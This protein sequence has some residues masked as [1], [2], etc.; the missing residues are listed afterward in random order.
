[1]PRVGQF[2]DQVQLDFFFPTDL[3]G[4]THL[5]LAMIDCATLLHQVRRCDSRQAEYVF[6]VFSEAW[7]LPFGL[8]RDVVCDMDGAFRGFFEDTLRLLGVNVRFAAPGA[9]WQIGKIESHD[10]VFCTMLERV[11]DDMAVINGEQLDVAIVACAHA[12]NSRVKQGGRTA[13]QAAFGRIPALPGELLSD[14]GSSSAAVWH[15]ISQ[16]QALAYAE[17]A[18]V[19]ALRAAAD[20]EGDQ[21]IRTAVLR[22][23]THMREFDP[24]PGQ[25]VCIWREQS[26]KKRH[27]KTMAAGFRPATFCLWD[28][29][30]EGR[31]AKAIAWVRCGTLTLAVAREQMR[32]A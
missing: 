14:E 15:N 16:R 25:A 32:P 27:G 20:I 4:F 19:S 3:T 11:I 31:G 1:M 12:K 6:R 2:G 30:S 5:L 24:E 22:K 10:D 9:H 18:R 13:F 23:A 28:P 29:G 17:E 8:P 7:L 21:A 26:G